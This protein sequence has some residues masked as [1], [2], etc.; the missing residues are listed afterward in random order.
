MLTHTSVLRYNILRKHGSELITLFR[1]MIPAGM[2]ELT[3]DEDIV[4]MV[5]KLA[6]ELDDKDAAETFRKEISVCLGDTYRRVD[7]MIHNWKQL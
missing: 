7:N 6:L 5:D 2:P 4:Y 3:K 1:L